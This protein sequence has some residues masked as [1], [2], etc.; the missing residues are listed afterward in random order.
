MGLKVEVRA[1]LASIELARQDLQR[2][3]IWIYLGFAIFQV[4][5]KLICMQTPSQLP[6]F[7]ALNQHEFQ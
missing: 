1:I 4:A 7:E 5:M 3:N 2:R 6:S